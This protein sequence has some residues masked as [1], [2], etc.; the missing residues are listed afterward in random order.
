[1]IALTLFVPAL[2]AMLLLP[3]VTRRQAAALIPAAALPALALGLVPDTSAHAEGVLLGLALTVDAVNR[4]LLLLTGLAWAAAAWHARR[5]VRRRPLAFQLFWLLTLEALL[6]ALLAA[7]AAGFY[8]GYVGVTLAVYGLVIHERTEAAMRAGRVYIV[9][10]L[11]GEAS[12]LTGLLLLGAR[13][14]NV[15]L[16][17]LGMLY[18]EGAGGAG[19]SGACLFLGFAVKMGTVPLHM[20]LPL[21]HPVAPVPASA[22]LSGVLVKAGLIGWLRFLPPEAWPGAPP[23]GFA[24]ALGLFSAFYGVAAGLGQARLKTVLAYSTVSQMGLVLVAF[25]LTWPSDAGRDLMLPVVGLLV[26]HHGLNKAALFLAAGSRPGASRLRLG[27]LALPALSLAGAPFTSGSL[28]KSAVGA[29]FEAGGLGGLE[30]LLTLSSLATAL[31]MLRVFH[32]ARRDAERDQPLAPAWAA[33][34][35]LG[36]VAPWFWAASHGLAYVP[37][38][39]GLWDGFWPLL[40]AG[41]I[42]WFWLRRGRRGPALPEGDI[43]VLIEGLGRRAAP[44]QAPE[45]PR[46]L[47]VP[48]GGLHVVLT[49]AI[50]N[51]ERWLRTLPAAGLLLLLIATLLWPLLR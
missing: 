19:L 14:G 2:L 1:M 46:W 38:L 48:E 44:V 3:G 20:W 7:D 12:I 43:L 29:G 45:R 25:A 40:A 21:A 23:I 8:L 28:A 31:L 41:G 18:A 34:T 9:M 30:I 10:A 50:A 32:L 24:V 51:S 11:L 5:T 22:V 15:E 27:L 42:A 37:G 35:A 47:Q 13:F 6:V 4:P 49:V 16:A 39:A 26:L 36:L 17:E 33:L